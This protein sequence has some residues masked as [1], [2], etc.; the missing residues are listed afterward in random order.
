MSS[1]HEEETFR[2]S[3]LAHVDKATAGN[4]RVG[5]G[6]GG[7]QGPQPTLVDACNLAADPLVKVRVIIKEQIVRQKED[8]AVE[9]EHQGWCD[10]RL[11]RK[12][13]VP[14]RAEAVG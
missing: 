13:W 2:A 3:Y 5:I 11:R 14:N 7:R 6:L 12:G 8:S 9:A 10:A 4:A 1:P